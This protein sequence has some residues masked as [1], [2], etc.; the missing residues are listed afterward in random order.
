MNLRGLVPRHD[1][2]RCSRLHRM[3]GRGRRAAE[4]R[5]LAYIL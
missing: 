1:D 2:G 3:G 4:R 5:G